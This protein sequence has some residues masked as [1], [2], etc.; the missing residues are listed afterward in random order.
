MKTREEVEALK[1][2]WLKD[3]CWRLEDAIGFEEYGV[4]LCAFAYEREA[5]WKAARGKHE[6]AVYRNTPA[7][8]TTLRDW[9]AV[10]AMEGI[11]SN[12]G[13]RESLTEHLRDIGEDA[14]L[15]ADAMMEAR[16]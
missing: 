3:P 12:V 14:Y 2:Q 11:I 10:H 5:E 7:S 4:E 8:E 1:A 16:R 9:F 6:A 15:M 13:R